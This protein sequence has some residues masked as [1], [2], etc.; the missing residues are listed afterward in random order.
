MKQPK[1]NS[2]MQTYH[3]TN[4]CNREES[5]NTSS[6]NI[7][8]DHRIKKITSK[9]SEIKLQNK[10]NN[11]SLLYYSLTTCRDVFYHSSVS[12]PCNNPPLFV[13]HPVKKKT[14]LE[15]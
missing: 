10:P 11:V 1:K 8:T 4:S 2:N 6:W 9:K 12:F 7:L 13:S 5:S 15:L 14:H 3:I